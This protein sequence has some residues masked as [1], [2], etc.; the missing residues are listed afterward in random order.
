M[1]KEQLL[2]LYFSNSLTTNQ[3]KQ[4]NELLVSDP[5]FKQQ[6]D[7]EKDLQNVIRH[8]ETT[9]LKE[10]L[11]GFE[12]EYSQKTPVRSI[13]PNFQKWSL[14]ASIAILCTLGWLG[15]KSFSGPDYSQ[16]YDSNFQEYP[17]TVFEI[18]RGESVESV[19]RAAFSAYETGD[20][21]TA[22]DYF[23]Q[24]KTKPAHVNFY[25]AQSYLNLKKIDKAET[26]FQKV[27]TAK[28]EFVAESHWYIAL[29]ALKKE[30]KTTA[31]NQLKILTEGYDYNKDNAIELLNSL[32]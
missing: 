3:Q 14:A 10:R 24:I 19:E 2:Q 4:F 11:V 31:V 23:A 5:E 1:D 28:K 30:D 27:I 26:F 9:D 7:F 29:I 12:K 22:V 13:R 25:L 32:E 17:N 16:L 18:S 8:K 6:F 21:A 20:Y 15:Y